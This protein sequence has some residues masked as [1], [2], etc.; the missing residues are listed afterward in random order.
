M[1][2]CNHC[3]NYSCNVIADFRKELKRPKEQRKRNLTPEELAAG[4]ARHIE[5]PPLKNSMFMLGMTRNPQGM[6]DTLTT[7]GMKII[8]SRRAPYFDI[9]PQATRVDTDQACLAQ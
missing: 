2:Q 6:V 4:C 3:A 9:V 8:D 5:P 7:L 1:R